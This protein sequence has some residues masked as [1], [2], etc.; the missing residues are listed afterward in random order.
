ML[1]QIDREELR[2][3]LNHPKNTVVIEAL[4]PEQ[5][6][7]AHLPGA[8]NIPPDQ[9]RR[10]APELIPKK[11]QEIVVYC[12]GP[13]CQASYQVAHELAAIGY[14]N[15]RHYAGGK[16]DWMA[17]DLPIVREQPAA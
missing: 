4:P 3:K 2:E 15:V 6:R 10:L 12:A 17:A 5:Y 9:L 14:S 16:S 11:D 7:E 8:L 1:T 13:T